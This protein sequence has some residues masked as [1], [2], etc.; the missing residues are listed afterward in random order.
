MN[1]T[2]ALKDRWFSFE[3][4]YTTYVAMIYGGKVLCRRVHMVW[5]KI[6]I[7]AFD[8]K[9]RNI[10][11]IA[12]NLARRAD[13]RGHA[14]S[15]HYDVKEFRENGRV[16]C[17]VIDYCGH[18]ELKDGKV[19]SNTALNTAFVPFLKYLACIALSLLSIYLFAGIITA[20]NPTLLSQDS[21]INLLVYTVLFSSLLYG[22][23]KEKPWYCAIIYGLMP[24]MCITVVSAILVSSTVKY[25]CTVIGVAVLLLA[26]ITWIIMKYTGTKKKHGIKKLSKSFFAAY[27]AACMLVTHTVTVTGHLRSSSGDSPDRDSIME[28]YFLALE[29]LTPEN[30]G[31]H[32]V[33]DRRKTLGAIAMYECEYV[34]GYS[35]PDVVVESLGGTVSG[36]YNDIKNTIYIDDDHIYGSDV[37][38]V[39]KTLL[40]EARHGYQHNMVSAYL[41][42]R[43]RLTET[44]KRLE[45][46]R[47]AERYAENLIDYKDSSENYGDYFLQELEVD[48]RQWSEIRIKDYECW[49]GTEVESNKIIL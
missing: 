32:T 17:G 40:H 20:V 24:V 41:R 28:E 49:I 44:E 4:D 37:R 25:V 31:L 1:K 12:V 11:K 26:S 21:R 9:S 14:S 36:S 2:A 42:I 16:R 13:A 39:V 23:S 48:S 47:K 34:L 35:T 3:K 27:I 38:D 29:E 7:G 45:P 22:I 19:L 33:E 18:I 15:M 5:G 43:D 10:N 46:F 6:F 8:V 30:W